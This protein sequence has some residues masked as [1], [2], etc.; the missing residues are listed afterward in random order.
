MK[1]LRLILSFGSHEYCASFPKGH[2][3]LNC[4]SITY[5]QPLTLR[6]RSLRYHPYRKGGR[7][8]SNH[9]WSWFLLLWSKRYP[10]THWSWLV[11]WYLWELRWE[12]G[13]KDFFYRFLVLRGLCW[14]LLDRW[15]HY[16]LNQIFRKCFWVNRNLLRWFCLS[17]QLEEVLTYL[18]VVV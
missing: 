1:I 3:R 18:R 12:K 17:R 14:F 2:H 8:S 11:C 9:L 16:D 5:R 15:Y 13:W 4:L 10:R 6:N 7:L